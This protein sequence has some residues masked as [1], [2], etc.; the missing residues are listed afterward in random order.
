MN[1]YQRN[2]S[3]LSI[4]DHYGSENQI[5][6]CKEEL[7]ELIEAINEQNRDHV[8]EEMADVLIM[9]KQLELM[10]EATD[11]VQAMIDYKILRTLGRMEE[12]V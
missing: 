1:D 4:I 11:E 9:C 10:A 2:R 3:L 12:H 8:I 5:E 6:K 7:G